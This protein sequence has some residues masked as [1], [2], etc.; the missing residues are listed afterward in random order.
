MKKKLFGYAI[1]YHDT[2]NEPG[3]QTVIKTTILQSA[4]EVLATSAKEAYTLA[5]MA[6]PPD[7]RDKMEF[8]E[9]L[10]WMVVPTPFAV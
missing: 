1:L 6:V 7:Y 3:K 5:S 4:T 9:V 2:I 10:V 8:V